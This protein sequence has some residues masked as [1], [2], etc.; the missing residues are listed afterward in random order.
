M[1]NNRNHRFSYALMENTKKSLFCVGTNGKR[2][3]N[4]GVAWERI[5]NVRKTCVLH[6][7]LWKT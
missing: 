6:R 3:E 7:N 5:E 2:K 1:E 4:E